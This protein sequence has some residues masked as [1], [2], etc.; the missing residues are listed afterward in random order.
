MNT[1]DGRVNENVMIKGTLSDTMQIKGN[2]KAG[3]T[4]T[5]RIGMGD[6]IDISRD[7]IIEVVEQYM[8]EHPY[9]ETDP[10]VPEWAKA[11]ENPSYTKQEID[12]KDLV[13]HSELEAVADS[14]PTE[15]Q[16][17]TSDSGHR[18]VTDAEKTS[19]NNKSDFSGSYNDL[20]DTP[21]PYDDSALRALINQK[22]PAGDYATNTKLQ[23]EIGEVRGY[24]AQELELVDA[25]IE[26][27]LKIEIFEAEKEA[28]EGQ[29]T[30]VNGRVTT[31]ATSVS[32]L[33]TNLTG[34]I[35]DLAD[36]VSADKQELQGN[37][38][39]ITTN[40]IMIK[41]INK[42]GTMTPTQFNALPAGLYFVEKPIQRMSGDVSVL[43][44][45]SKHGD[46]VENFEFGTYFSDFNGTSYT[47]YGSIDGFG[48]KESE[49]ALTEIDGRLDTLEALPH[50][51]L[52]TTLTQSGK[53]SDAKVVGDRIAEIELYKFPNTTIVGEPTINHGQVSD[54]SS[55][56]YLQFPFL[57]DF[58]GRQFTIN[59]NFTT[60]S[61]II[62]QQNIFGSEYGL[63]FY[64]KN[65]HF[66]L[67]ASSNGTSWNL[68][69]KTGTY[70]VIPNTPYYIRLSWNRLL[71]RVEYSLDGI[72]YTQDFTITA[73][74]SPYPRT[75]EIGIASI[76]EPSYPFKGAVNLNNCNLYIGSELV[77]SGMDDV[78]LATRLATD[79]SNLDALGIQK[80]KDIIWDTVQDGNEVEY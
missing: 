39:A 76:T 77:W 64:I 78:G 75:I 72:S 12:E 6:I 71:Y 21:E 65:G 1:L 20:T 66:V 49:V 32:T 24:I 79:M 5:G 47:T 14:V 52:D 13:S 68:G 59:M 55:T 57:V 60:G 56:S 44:V 42:D 50:I 48:Y 8:E 9:I 10:T 30:T 69:E 80:I 19:W 70:T 43:G 11:E 74:Q 26:E 40:N 41:I 36:T 73:A 27:R 54:F 15:L 45:C 53:A 34:D 4:M 38:D 61:D 17:L 22:Q 67:S 33:E 29:I 23:E 62:T 35:D 51:E 16:Q 25:D 3:E 28:I 63:A 46:E 37:I 7:Q 31:V 2:L 18:T 58:Q